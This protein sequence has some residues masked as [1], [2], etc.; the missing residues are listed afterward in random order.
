MG[1]LH[2]F[3][4]S[5]YSIKNW[6]R[7]CWTASR[8]IQKK[9]RNGNP[10]NIVAL[11]GTSVNL[12][13]T[14]AIYLGSGKVVLNDSW[15]EANPFKTLLSMRDNSSL[16][17]HGSLSIYSNAD[18]SVNDNAV[19][20]IGSGFINHG[21][22]IHAF[23]RITIGNGVFIGDDV[24]IRDSDGHNIVGSNKQMTMPIIIEDHVWI[25]AKVTIIKG[26]TI[27]AGAVVAAGAVVTKDVPA[28]TLVAGV[29]ARIVK[30]NVEWK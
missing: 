24:A 18:I 25:G 13:S 10:S 8:K 2:K 21:A 12:N 7:I 30:E 19:L 1:I 11:K 27:G 14:A 28:N 26:V 23:D 3:G 29:P 4:L 9:V 6:K 16:V 22:R 17:V 20:E 5:K 15:C